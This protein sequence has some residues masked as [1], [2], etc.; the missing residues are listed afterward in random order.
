MFFSEK[1]SSGHEISEVLRATHT[2]VPEQTHPSGIRTR[3]HRTSRLL[4]PLVA[5]VGCFQCWILITG[6]MHYMKYRCCP[7]KKKSDHR[8]FF[9]GLASVITL[10]VDQKGLEPWVTTASSISILHT[11]Q[12]TKIRLW[13]FCHTQPLQDI[14]ISITKTI[15]KCILFL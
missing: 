9:F 6:Q 1:K 3:D 5:S 2:E 8:F 7:Q 14:Q 4:R 10:W 11:L 12:C 15:I 13:D